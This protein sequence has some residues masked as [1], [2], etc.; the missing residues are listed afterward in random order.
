MI[1]VGNDREF[2]FLY[3]P[4]RPALESVFSRLLCGPVAE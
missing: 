2:G 3:H 1:D 4:E